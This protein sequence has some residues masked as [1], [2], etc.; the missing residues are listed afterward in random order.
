MN[1]ERRTEEQLNHQSSQPSF[2]VEDIMEEFG[3]T[4]QP[5]EPEED[6]RIWPPHAKPE[7][8]EPLIELRD[9]R[10]EPLRPFEEIA[11]PEEESPQEEEA[12][13]EPLYSPRRLLRLL[14]RL[15]GTRKA[16]EEE[17][18]FFEEEPPLKTPEEAAEEYRP[19]VRR[20][21]ICAAV[22]WVLM[23]LSGAAMVL[24]AAPWNF[25]SWLTVPLCNIITL[26]AL[27]LQ[28]LAA[29]DLMGSGILAAAKGKI[30]VPAVLLLT[31]MLTALRGFFTIADPVLS[32]S[33]A[34]GFLLTVTLWGEYLL[35]SA[36]LRTLE[37]LLHMESPLAAA[38]YA[39]V[40]G[41]QDGLYRCGAETE[42]FAADLEEEPGGEK[43][44]RITLTILLA[45]S[46]VVA[47]ILALRGGVDFLWSFTVLL[48]GICPVGGVLAYRRTF[49]IA[50]KHLKSCGAAL[51][52]WTGAKNLDGDAC[53]VLTD[54]DLFPHANVAL[55]GIKVFGD[56]TP[57]RLLGY[58][59]ALLQRSGA[60]SLCR[61]F[62][63]VLATQNGRRYRTGDFRNYEA[64][65][66]GGEIQGEIVLLGSLGFMD[67]MGVE[68]PPEV[69]LRQALYISVGGRAEGVFAI[70]YRPSDAVRS[71]LSAL[72]SCRRILPI[73][74]T[75]DA[76]LTP[77]MV[78]KTYGIPGDLLEYPV[79]RDRA[80]LLSAA[81][82][83]GKQGACLARDSFL[84]FSVAVATARQMTKS[85]RTAYVLSIVAA[86]LGFL[87]LTVLTVGNFRDAA[88]VMQILF[89]HCIWLLPVGLLTG[90]IRK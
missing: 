30:T 54:E 62:E 40:Y 44:V 34:A 52:G 59:A 42:H 66:L 16:E 24:C 32:Y 33:S 35:S 63:D 78:R 41:G 84:S 64:G 43:A 74:A 77:D 20:Q 87:L 72:L 14:P 75:Q 45:A 79:Y 86:V 5:Q 7:E 83:V 27:L 55:N 46:L 51:T 37:M 12:D 6:V 23:V 47:A 36:K 4:P 11:P 90:R 22:A 31:V 39:Q 81:E 53:V 2:T 50:S 9:P 76:L 80:Q 8:T 67:L 3:T 70:H 26:S 28:C 1:E 29:A 38:R 60:K 25:T 56:Y 85:V 48:L 58:A 49:C 13:E 57:E 17:I 73:L 15:G 69:R 82:G 19:K 61:V 71:G 18:T 10:E 89:Y 65:G 68:I 21:K 88:G